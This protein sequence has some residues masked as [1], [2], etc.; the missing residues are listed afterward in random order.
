MPCGHASVGQ[1]TLVGVHSYD[2]GI[3]IRESDL[4]KQPVE[5]F[6]QPWLVT[7]KGSFLKVLLLREIKEIMLLLIIII[8]NMNNNNNK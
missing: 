3:E 7:Y 5:S 6:A 2:L 4:Y 1:R 8:I